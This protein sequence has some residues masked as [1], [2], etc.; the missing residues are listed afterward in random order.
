MEEEQT[1]SGFDIV[2]MWQFGGKIHKT[3]HNIQM[4]VIW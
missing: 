4:E 3:Q 1:I 2:V